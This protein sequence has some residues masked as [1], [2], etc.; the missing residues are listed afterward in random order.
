MQ[1]IYPSALQNKVPQL[2]ERRWEREK[3]QEKG[4]G[5]REG[6]EKQHVA[7]KEKKTPTI[8][9]RLENIMLQN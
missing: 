7:F 1:L 5:G 8:T 6:K 3:E 2:Q 9:G 4:G